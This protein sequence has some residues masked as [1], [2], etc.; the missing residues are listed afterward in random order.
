MGKVGRA[1]AVL[2]QGFAPAGRAP[3]PTLPIFV[4]KA[5]PAREAE[6]VRMT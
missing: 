1:Q 3:L 4:A 5:F 6:P 2:A